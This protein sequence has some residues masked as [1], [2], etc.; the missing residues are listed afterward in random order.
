MTTYVDPG[1]YVAETDFPSWLAKQ[2]FPE[3]YE[4]IFD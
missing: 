1:P 4:S 2:G 3:T